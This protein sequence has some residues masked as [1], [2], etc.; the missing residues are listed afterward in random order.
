MTL[1][2]PIPVP[3]A[4][5]SMAGRKGGPGTRTMLGLAALVALAVFGNGAVLTMAIAIFAAQAALSAI[6]LMPSRRGRL[7]ARDK[8]VHRRPRVYTLH[9]ATHNEPPEVVIRTIRGL[10]AQVGAPAYEVIV[11]DNNTQDARLWKPVAAFCEGR[12]GVRFLHRDGVEGAKA[13][14]LAIARDMARPD[15]THVVTV[16]ADYAVT[17]DFLARADAALTETGADFVQFPQAYDR[18]SGAPGVSEELGDYFARFASHGDRRGATLLTGTL[19]VISLDAL[20]AVGGWRA[21]T[22]TEDAELG[23]RLVEA[24]YRGHFVPQVVGRGLLPL[25]AESLCAQR[26]RW[27]HGNAATFLLRPGVARSLAPV[28]QLLAWVNFQTFGAILLIWGLA[29]EL[30]D[31]RFGTEIV[32]LGVATL[33]LALLAAILPFATAS[34]GA[35][36]CRMALLPS[37]AS[38]TFEALC[39]WEQTFLRTSKLR[40][41]ISVRMPPEMITTLGLGLGAIVLSAVSGDRVATAGGIALCLPAV[42]YF[43]L[44]HELARYR[45]QLG[46]VST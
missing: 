9:V 13:G 1:H 42:A 44:E 25:S 38:A 32:G 24:G 14:A 34:L 17:S 11:L 4:R 2:T 39:G 30:F 20:D 41:E 31:L 6:Q 29:S 19:S 43:Y 40:E 16:D 33:F 27:A 5:A 15:A 10:L 22:V 18:D 37:S 3:P 26:R 21:V 12:N 45:R 7:I 23:T 28:R 36:T 46:E 8:P 35:A